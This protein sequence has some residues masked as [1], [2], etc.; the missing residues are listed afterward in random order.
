[1][2]LQTMVFSRIQVSMLIAF[3]FL[4]SSI[5]LISVSHA[6]N[7]H[8][9]HW[10][11]N[12]SDPL[13][14]HP[15]VADDTPQLIVVEQTVHVTWLDRHPL[16]L[17]YTR[18]TNEG[19]T[20]ASPH[21]IYD[22]PENPLIDTRGMP[23]MVVQ[24]NTVHMLIMRSQ[25]VLYLRSRDAGASWEEPR[26]LF[27]EPEGTG[28]GEG[29]GLI[30]G[31]GSEVTIVWRRGRNLMQ[32]P[33]DSWIMLLTSTD[34]GDTWGEARTIAYKDSDTLGA[35]D[36]YQD[37]HRIYVLY[38][39]AAFYYGMT[40]SNLSLAVST[41]GGEHFTSHLLSVPSSNGQHKG[42]TQHNFHYAPKLAVNGDHVTVVW[43]GLDASD[44]TRIFAAHSIDGGTTFSPTIPL[45]TD[46]NP[47]TSSFATGQELVIA[48]GIY[49]YVLFVSQG[50]SRVWLVRSTTS[51]TSFEPARE[52]TLPHSAYLSGGWW[53]EAAF[54]PRDTTGATLHVGWNPAVSGWS[55]NGGETFR[56]TRLDPTPSIW[57]VGNAPGFAIG[58]TGSVH[59]IFVARLSEGKDNDIFYRRLTASSVPATQDY[60]LH[61]E[62]HWE[63]HRFDS[64]LLPASTIA[65]TNAL[66][67]EA[68]VRPQ[69]GSPQNMHIISP[70]NTRPQAYLLRTY[71]RY[72]KRLPLAVLFTESGQHD[73][74]APEGYVLADGVWTHLAMTYDG[75]AATDNFRLYV[76]GA[77]ASS[78]PL[79]GTLQ[80]TQDTMVVGGQSTTLFDGDI[81]ELRLW[82]HARS[83]AEIRAAMFTPLQDTLSGLFAYYPL[84]ST[85]RDM[86]GHGN[87]GV[88]LYQE[89]FVPVPAESRLPGGAIHLSANGSGQLQVSDRDLQI[90]LSFPEQSVAATTFVTYTGM[91]TV[92][93][94][95]VTDHTLL[96]CFTLKAATEDGRD[97]TQ[98]QQPF[99]LRLTYS[100]EQLAALGVPD[101][102]PLQIIF[103]NG[104]TWE[105]LE[106]SVDRTKQQAQAQLDHMTPFALV[107]GTSQQS[108][109]VYLPFVRKQ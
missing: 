16:R 68:W 37:T 49:V 102:A 3:F 21:M 84:D 70:P 59:S 9:S 1:M 71:D 30:A 47:P 56:F 38:L 104:N 42:Y 106:T 39:D 72:G 61:L 12:L 79:T 81:D 90:E 10:T 6:E 82:Q 80:F 43:E 53:V 69:A 83:S 101:N 99:T 109:S 97:V 66:T 91:L 100:A 73:L 108:L 92:P 5:A 78:K 52:V 75:S 87:D 45:T 67:V 29:S 58:S 20:F 23:R 28:I 55:S 86:S 33:Q 34:N 54:D 65:V 93:H 7:P 15:E 60:A 74:G 18:S 44:T 94:P 14:Q 27:T 77:L 36:L 76:N 46:Q 88:L 31:D 98:F 41:D 26:V 4:L 24:G 107:A 19:Q 89:Q 51:G 96:G 103:W 85:T 13:G 50:D 63:Q 64:M 105:A 22:S 40:Y 48:R 17:F 35:I 11:Q 62:T 25:S 57:T 95:L 32:G 8:V 2:M